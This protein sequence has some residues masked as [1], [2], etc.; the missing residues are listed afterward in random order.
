[1][2]F[3]I[4]GFMRAFSYKKIAKSIA[5]QNNIEGKI[6]TDERVGCIVGEAVGNKHQLQ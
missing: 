1:M 6:S 2:K 3:K 5:K 4:Y